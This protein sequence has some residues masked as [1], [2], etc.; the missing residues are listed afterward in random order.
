LTEKKK[1]L[2]K[3]VSKLEAESDKIAYGISYEYQDSD[4]TTA[5]KWLAN[6][7]FKF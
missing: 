2:E 4:S 6:V 3:D 1:N 7:T 5:N